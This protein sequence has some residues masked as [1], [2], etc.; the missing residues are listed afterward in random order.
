MIENGENSA[1]VDS[2]S[3]K[4]AVPTGDD[5]K[6]DGEEKNDAEA[7]AKSDATRVIRYDE[8]YY[9]LHVSNN[10]RHP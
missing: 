9:N 2:K 3:K 5:K 1:K 4:D 6:E 7:K 10:L 8:V